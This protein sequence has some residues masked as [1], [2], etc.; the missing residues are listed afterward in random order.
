MLAITYVHAYYLLFNINPGAHMAITQEEEYELSERSE[1]LF[2]TWWPD[3]LQPSH[4]LFQ[5]R[6]Y[7]LQ[8]RLIAGHMQLMSPADKRRATKTLAGLKNRMKEA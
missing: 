8:A 5:T 1:Q 6:M 7:E 2:D 4:P 3:H